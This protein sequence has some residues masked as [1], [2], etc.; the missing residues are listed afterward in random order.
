MT[1]GPVAIVTGGTRG[2]GRAVCERLLADGWSVMATYLSDDEGAARFAETSD[3][4]R[5]DARTSECRWTV[6]R[7]WKRCSDA[8]GNWTIS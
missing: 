6:R 5:S 1:N 7:R 2:I 4:L 3:R 8:S